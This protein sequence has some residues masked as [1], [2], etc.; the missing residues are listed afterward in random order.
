[1]TCPPKQ[2]TPLNFGHSPETIEFWRRLVSEAL[3]HVST[4]LYVFSS[5]PVAARIAEI[6][7]ELVQAGFKASDTGRPGAVR[8]RHWLSC[9]TQ[10][11]AP[12]LHWWHNQGRPI[13]VVSEF[14]L[15]AALAVG[16][17][18]EEILVNGPAKH[19]W[20]KEFDLP[21]LSVHFDSPD[22]L[23]ALLPTAKK[24]AWRLGIRILTGEEFDSENPQF[25]TQFGF[26]PATAVKRFIFICEP[27]SL[28]S[29]STNGPLRK[30]RRFAGWQILNRATWT[31]AAGFP[32]ARF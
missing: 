30:W 32:C 9:K 14:E 22:E 5:E 26:E 15:R 18:P 13:E 29:K 11:V 27:M 7:H 23:S 8:F 25:P 6:D 21:G 3:P 28:P 12:L 31:S 16:F 4:P 2:A 17:A 1:V 20:L 19:H 24:S 10:P